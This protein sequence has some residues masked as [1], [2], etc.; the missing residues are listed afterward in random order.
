MLKLA[1]TSEPPARLFAGAL[2]HRIIFLS[3]KK[4]N[5]LA[6][7]NINAPA[8]VA[9]YI[10]QSFNAMVIEELACAGFRQ[11]WAIKSFVMADAAVLLLLCSNLLPLP[12]CLPHPLFPLPPNEQAN[13][14][15]ASYSVKSLH[16][17]PRSEAFF[18][19]MSVQ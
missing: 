19:E 18:V 17:R 10:S 14:C 6:H 8:N 13:K 12:H 1:N 16:R 4:N 15:R 3:K 7:L 2:Q 11:D 9:V 5:Y